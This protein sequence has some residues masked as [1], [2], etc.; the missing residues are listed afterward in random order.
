M[1]R[2]KRERYTVV[3][4]QAVKTGLDYKDAAAELGECIFHALQCEGELD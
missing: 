3:Y 1:T 2:A 4:G